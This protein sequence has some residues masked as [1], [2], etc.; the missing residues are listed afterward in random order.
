MEPTAAKQFF[1]T[2]VIEEAQAE[3]VHLSNESL[4]TEDTGEHRGNEAR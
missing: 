4:S 3:Q 1:I 2:R